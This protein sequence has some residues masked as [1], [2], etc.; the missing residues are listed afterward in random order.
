[1]L[2]VEDVLVESC[3]ADMFVLGILTRELRVKAQEEI[4]VSKAQDG[5]EIETKHPYNVYKR[6]HMMYTL[7]S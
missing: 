4:E 2:D 3:L 5:R 1:M 7:L 6:E